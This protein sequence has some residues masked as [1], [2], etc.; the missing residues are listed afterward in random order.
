MNSARLNIFQA[1]NSARLNIF[2]A[3]NSP[4][5]NIF[6]AMNSA[7]LNSKSLRYQKYSGRRY[8]YEI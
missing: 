7:R 3:M 4:R 6:Q 2:Q 1:I 8:K 5:L